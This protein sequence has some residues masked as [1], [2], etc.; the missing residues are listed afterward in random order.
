MTAVYSPRWYRVAGLKPCLSATLQLRRQ[1]VRGVTWILLSERG[2]GRSVRLNAAAWALAARFDGRHSVQA[3]WDGQF[4]S[5]EDPPTQD[6]L[7]D[8]LAQLRDAALLQFDRAPDDEALRAPGP[9]PT[10]RHRNSLIAWRIPLGDPTRLLNR[11]AP[12]L[13]GLLFSRPAALLWALAV[14]ALLLAAL[15][16]APSLVAHGREWMATPRYALLAALLYVPVKALHELAHGLAVRHWGGSVRRAGITLM[17]GLPVP[18]V[19]A[20]AATGFAQRRRR[21]L[22]GAAGMMV[23]LALAAAALPLWLALPDGLARDAA[24]VTLFITGVSTLLFNANPLQRLDGYYIAID[25]LGLPNLATRSRQWWQHML[26]R[27][28]L[29]LPGLEPMALARG[30]APWLAAYAPLSWGWTLLI[31]GVA[32]T[33]L[34]QLSFALGLL[35]GVLLGWQMVLRPVVALAGGLHRAALAGQASAR[36]WQR[37]ALAGA[38]ALALL[39]LLPLPQHTRLQGVVWPADQA[40]LRA[41]EDG[42][43]KTLRVADGQAVAPGDTVLELANPALQT[44]LT[45]QQARVSA[46]EAELVQ[47]LTGPQDTPDAQRAA[48]A[49]ARAGDA[50]AELGR[51]Q[52]ELDRLQDRVT[53]LTVRARAAGRV[54]LPQAADLPGQYLHRGSLVGQVL[55]GAPPTVRVALPESDAGALR[56]AAPSVSVRLAASAGQAHPARL[57]RDGTGAVHQLPS[58]AL[59]QRHG[60]PV[61]TDPKDPTDLQP[62]QPVVLLDLQLADGAP[63]ATRLGERAW[64][65]FDDGFAP[66]AW[67]LAGALQRD[68]Q[69][70][71]NPQ[72]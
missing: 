44:Q 18:W 43:V 48:G 2:G 54:A 37:L 40:Q 52:A 72:F 17:M 6:E 14:A 35:G 30:E 57:L 8:L 38:A 28:L 36:R 27:R 49:D 67:Q 10:Q 68:L 15:Q 32:I 61:A 13:Q 16:H 19:D 26:R 23:E 65:R 31:A 55:S 66:L 45:R 69:Q 34:G 7:I 53:A 12:P 41:D 51:A 56:Q 63:P 47:A 11:L 25:L 21:M 71:F 70:R 20:S 5:G 22:V 58:A 62:V 42:F 29:R 59:S 9:D 4:A 46:L 24:F 64:V 60:G 1:Q 33:W 39:L 50:Q 3:V